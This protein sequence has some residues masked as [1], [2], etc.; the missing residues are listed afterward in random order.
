M[1]ELTV[2]RWET[3]LYK[4][5]A[6]QHGRHETRASKTDPPIHAGGRKDVLDD[7]SV[8]SSRRDEIRP[9]T[10]AYDLS[11]SNDTHK[12]RCKSR[13]GVAN[14]ESIPGAERLDPRCVTLK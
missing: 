12:T 14:D 11:A 7:I 4:R 6:A 8:N 2:A 9:L 10:A 5:S 13:E 1:V 3:T